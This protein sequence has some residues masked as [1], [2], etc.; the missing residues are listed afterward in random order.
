MSGR[1]RTALLAAVAVLAGLLGLAGQAGVSPAPA[2]AAAYG[3]SPAEALAQA[4]AQAAYRGVYLFGA[5]VDRR[6]GEVFARTGNA[7]QQVASESLMKLHLTAYYLRLYGGYDKTPTSVKDRLT[8]MLKYSDDDTASS[9][10]SSAAIPTVAAAYGL[11]GTSNAY[12]NAG[13]WGAARVTADDMAAFLFRA[14]KDP[15]V[16]PWLIPALANTA[17]TGS[18]ADAGFNQAFGMNALAGEHGSKQGWGCDSYWTAPTCAIHSVG[19]TDEYFVSLLQ[20]SAS[21]PDP[22]RST[23]T[24]AAQ[25][26]QAS[27][28][29][30]SDG[31]FVSN[32]P[33]VYRMAGGAPMYVSSWDRFGGPQPV[34]EL[35]ASTFAKLAQ[36][37]ADGTFVFSQAN[38]EVYRFAGGAPVYV[39][40][41]AP[42]G[43]PQPMVGVD[44]AVLANAGGGGVF[45]HVRFRP[46][47]GTV[48]RDPVSGQVFVTA[49]GSPLAA[50][51]WEPLGGAR[52]WVD[53]DPVALR[54]AGVGGVFRFLRGKPSDGTLIRDGKTQAVYQVA[55][56][57]PVYVSSWAP[58]G[59]P[60]PTTLV[61]GVVLERAGSGWPFHTLSFYPADG[62]FVYDRPTGAV[63]RFAG[64]AP[65]YV[66]S[67]APFGGPQPM[68]ALDAKAFTNAGG[69]G[70][71]SHVRLRPVDGT[72]LRDPVS[73]SVFVTAGG[74]PLAVTDWSAIGGVR[75]WVDVDPV[76]LRSAGVGGVFR[77]LRGKPSDGTLIRDGK[78]QAVY[79]VA[80]GA[81]VY[82]SSWAPFG[83]PQPTTLVDG[84]TLANAGSGWPFHTLSF[85]PA[86]GTLLLVWPTGV[87]LQTDGAGHVALS[88]ASATP[89]TPKVNQDVVDRAGSGGYFNHLV[90]W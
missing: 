53:V 70:F 52:P 69:G 51:S 77:F 65:V 30:P 41:W 64:G 90:G 81:P 39:S 29:I 56:G 68:V 72:V 28:A 48:L 85:Y 62:T 46:S 78:T 50:L 8:Y 9:M 32:G 88:M 45:S 40:S 25:R 13:Y 20:L 10:F 84:V 2:Q 67:W 27:T 89:W 86:A 71:Y 38:G 63:Y 35:S 36:Y 26:V 49:G 58:F 79:Q 87:V 75:P 54:S 76:A 47:D 60:Q 5:V 19:Y 1:R 61:D 11:T 14:S 21:Y 33:D 31:Q 44:P 74:S 59:G 23:S 37:P 42:F 43:G 80:G 18:G 17:P 3:S 57:A 22:M 15:Q 24:A 6:S 82:V 55:G 34:R 16:G 66:S 12:G 4:E 73:G 83:G 7:G